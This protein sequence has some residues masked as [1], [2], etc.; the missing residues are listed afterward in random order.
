M[1]PYS[2]YGPDM[3]GYVGCG[4]IILLFGFVIGVAVTVLIWALRS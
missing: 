1:H 3:K 4:V 2:N